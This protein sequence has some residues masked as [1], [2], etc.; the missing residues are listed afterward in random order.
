MSDIRNATYKGHDGTYDVCVRVVYDR[1]PESPREDDNLGTIYHWHPNYQLGERV[2]I[3]EVERMVRGRLIW[4]PVYMFDHSGVTIATTPFACP[5]DS[6]QVGIIAV[7]PEECDSNWGEWKWTI[8]QAKEMLAHEINTYDQYLRGEIFGF[9]VEVKG[10]I[11]DSCWGFYSERHAWDEA[12][13]ASR[14]YME[15]YASDDSRYAT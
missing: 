5:W 6:G 1:D 15:A 12:Q 4:L 10:E 3:E 8:A 7:T 13:A 9:F 14:S 2:S 11:V